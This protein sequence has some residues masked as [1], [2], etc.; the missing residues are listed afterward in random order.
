[1][2]KLSIPSESEG[3]PLYSLPRKDAVAE[4]CSGEFKVAFFCDL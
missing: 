3:K 4:L 1:M 2:Q